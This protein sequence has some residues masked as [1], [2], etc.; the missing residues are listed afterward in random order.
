MHY[1]L[2]GI[3]RATQRISVGMII[4]KNHKFAV[5]LILFMY[6]LL[7][8]VVASANTFVGIEEQ[9]LHTDLQTLVEWGH[10]DLAVTTYPV[11]WKGIKQQLDKINPLDLSLPASQAARRLQHN[12]RMR[13]QQKYQSFINIHAATDKTRFKDFD[14]QHHNK[15]KFNASHFLQGQRWEARISA[16]LD[17]T[18]KANFDDSYINYQFDDWNIRVGAINQWWGPAQSSSL[19]LSS[20]ARPIPAISISRSKATV[21]KKPWLKHIGPWYFTAQLGQLESRRVVSNAKIWMTRFT[22]Q[23]IKGLELGASWTAVWGG[24]GFG[25]SVGD[26]WDVITFEPQC[27]NG[28]PACDDSLDTKK[29]NH[30]AGFDLKYTWNIGR[31]F[32]L[33]IQRIGEDAADYYNLSDQSTLFGFSSYVMG[34]KI[35]IESSDTNI[36]CG[37]EGSTAKNCFYEH[38]EYQSGYRRYSRAIGSTFD[39]DAKMLTL[40][41]IV[42]R[43][44]G[45]RFDF[46]LRHLELNKDG[47]RPSPV[48]N[49]NTEKLLQL[50]GAYQ[51]RLGKVL[52]KLGAQIESSKINGQSS[53]VSALAHTRLSF[54]F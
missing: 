24:D 40:G 3:K 28:A 51:I 38:G 30:L 53:T 5:T 22:A 15:A 25:N 45:G 46:T 7:K 35:Y 32:S 42:Q 48:V 34:A 33:Y 37:G 16:N 49:G 27:A 2:K 54:Q 21:S 20:N 4:L 11:P 39:S 9:Q 26:F 6:L 52:V 50:N 13:A 43:T 36:A 44:N 19:I 29:G 47:L 1:R 23:P 12:L 17:S 8:P 41:A 18:D 10:I 31:P 14:G